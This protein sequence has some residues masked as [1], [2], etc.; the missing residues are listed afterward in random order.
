MA[1]TDN[2]DADKVL[3]TV[4]SAIYAFTYKYPDSWIYAT[5]STA[6]KTRFYR[7]GINKYFE[8]AIEDFEIMGEIEN[9][10]EYFEVGKN[11]QA[12]AVKK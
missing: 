10:W 6:A 3:A 12:F 11:Y 8:I 5:G 9:E 2:G 7:M 1:I 4:V